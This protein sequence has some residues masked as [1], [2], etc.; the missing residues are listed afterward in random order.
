MDSAV[1]HHRLPRKWIVVR[2]PQVQH[3]R[4]ESPAE[5]GVLVHI[6]PVSSAHRD[7]RHA[8]QTGH[9]TQRPEEQKHPG[10]KE[11]IL[12]HRRPGT[13][14]QIQQVHHFELSYCQ[15]GSLLEYL[16]PVFIHQRQ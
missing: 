5:T 8:G 6:R 13:G 4:R 1:P 3:L 9:R 11:R 10:E 15:Y 7:P 14:C 12:L 16:K 2:L